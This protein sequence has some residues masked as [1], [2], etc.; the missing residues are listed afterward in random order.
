MIQAGGGDGRRVAV[1]QLKWNGGGGSIDVDVIGG[2][3]V[4]MVVV[5][6]GGLTGGGA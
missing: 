3:V 1:R 4:V 5:C 6:V 2:R